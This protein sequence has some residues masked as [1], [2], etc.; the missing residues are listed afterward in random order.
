MSS[1]TLARHIKWIVAGIAL[2]ALAVRVWSLPFGLPYLYHPDEPMY[3]SIAQDMFRSGDWNPHS[4][5]F[6]SLFFDINALAYF[7]FYLLGSIIGVFHSP[8]DIASPAMLMLGVGISPTPSTFLLG[9]SVSLL[10]GLGAVVL[11]FLV[12]KRL[13]GSMMVG[14][15]GALLMAISPGN[16]Q[17]SRYITPDVIQVFFILLAFWGAVLVFQRG[18]WRDYIL[19]GL[20]VGLAASGKYNGVL[21]GLSLV[22]AHFLRLGWRGVREMRLYLALALAPVAFFLT[23]P[24]ALFDTGTF[25][26]D[27]RSEAQHYSTGH[28]GMDG[29]TVKWYLDYLWVTGGPIGLL[30]LAEVG[31]G[32][33]LRLKPIILLSIFPVA[34]FIFI[35]SFPVRND[36]TALPLTPFMYLLA[37]SLLVMLARKLLRHTFQQRVR[38]AAAFGVATL[39]ALSIAYPAVATVQTTNSFLGRVESRELAR[40][41]IEENVPDGSTVAIESY[42]PYVDPKRYAVQGYTLLTVHTAEWYVT[43]GVDYLVFSEGEYGRFY[44]EPERYPDAVARY[45]ALFNAFESVKTVSVEGYDVR[46][47]MVNRR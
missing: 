10:F 28:I 36:R 41:W 23:T 29:D 37:S 33:Y 4:F 19:A 40:M 22:G 27:L 43:N 9:R 16:V 34:Y 6:P 17:H 2:L 21:I 42:S 14:L 5:V 15:L 20:A 13:T 38:M 25:L 39:A 35:N 26:A 3:V 12:G 31:R 8:D 46:I 7:P 24:Y 1:N 30:A 32:I 11:V 18:K 44:A 47:Y 45:N